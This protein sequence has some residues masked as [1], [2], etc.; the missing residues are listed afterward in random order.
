MIA[1]WGPIIEEYYAG[2]EANGLTWANS[3][4][5]LTHKGTVGRPIH[6]ELHICD[7][8]GDEVPIGQEGQIY[9]GG[10]APPNYHNAPEKNKSALN[11]KNPG[12]SSLGDVGKVDEDGFLY[13]T[14]LLYTS[15]SP[16]DS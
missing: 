1:W 12:W 4:D 8:A 9:F 15:P 13:L 3:A 6:G 10:T 7:E 16:R 5:W 11:P 14:C 2:S